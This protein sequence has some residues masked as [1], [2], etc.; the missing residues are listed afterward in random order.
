MGFCLGVLVYFG[1][2]LLTLSYVVPPDNIAER[3]GTFFIVIL[4][5]PIIWFSF[6][7]YLIWFVIKI[8]LKKIKTFN[9]M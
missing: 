2:G 5:W 9:F 6:I 7:I 8:W 1:V 3:R 4:G